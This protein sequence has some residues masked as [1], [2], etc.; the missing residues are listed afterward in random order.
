[1]AAPAD[2][3]SV[4]SL[5]G[6]AKA[7]VP[8]ISVDEAQKLIAE[9]ALLIDVRTPSEVE[10]S[11][12]A[13]DAKNVPR[14]FLEFKAGQNMFRAAPPNAIFIAHSL[15]FPPQIRHVQCTIPSLS[16]KGPSFFTVVLAVA[17]CLLE[18]YSWIWDTRV[19]RRLGS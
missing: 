8:S 1:M 5:I 17:L 6:A 19:F 18:N 3:L 13:I 2:L 16:V 4:K 7:A 10:K 9:G 12:K 11:G 14:G 15:I